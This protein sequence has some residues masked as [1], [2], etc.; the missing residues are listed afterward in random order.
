M[1][2]LGF[3]AHLCDS[4]VHAFICDLILQTKLRSTLSR[5]CAPKFVQSFLKRKLQITFLLMAMTLKF[6][7]L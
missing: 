3:A 6:D 4:T 7:V 5:P 1:E 2:E